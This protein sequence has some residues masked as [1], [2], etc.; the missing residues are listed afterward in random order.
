MEIFA[1]PYPAGMTG[2]E[3]TT[4]YALNVWFSLLSED[5]GEETG[6]WLIEVYELMVLASDG[7]E[8]EVEN[9]RKKLADQTIYLTPEETQIL[10]LGSDE[11]FWLHTDEFFDAFDEIPER[12]EAL[13]RGLPPY[14]MEI[15]RTQ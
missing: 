9:E 3:L 10:S 1:T 7:A 2:P 12:V 11:D 6:Y 13:L 4:E 5:N 14:E 15:V 8:Q